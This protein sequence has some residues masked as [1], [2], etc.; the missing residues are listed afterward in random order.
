MSSMTRIKA[1]ALVLALTFVMLA[2]VVQPA[3]ASPT[4]RLDSLKTYI[5]DQYDDVEGGYS[6]RGEKLSRGE[7]TFSV[8]EALN[9]L[10]DLAA[11]PPPIN[12]TMTKEFIT[13]LQW[14]KINEKDDKY[15][16]FS[17]F[18]AGIP[19][20]HASYWTIRAWQVLNQ[21]ND[22][23]G[24]ENVEINETA[25]LV[26]I[27]RTFTDEGGFA[28]KPGKSADL[29]STYEAVYLI[30]YLAK[31]IQEKEDTPYTTTVDKWLNQTAVFDY[32]L[33]CRK[34][35]AFKMTTDAK[36]T[37]VTATAAAILALDVLDR[38]NDLQD[39]QSV[40]D[41]ILDRQVITPIADE[42]VGGF[43]ESY[44]TNDTNLVSTYYALSALDKLGAIDGHVNASIAIEF[45][46]NCQAADGAWALTPGYEDGE[47]TYIGMA[48]MSLK[49]LH[50]DDIRS[51]LLVEDPNNPAP[52]LIDWRLGL[53]ILMLVIAA[54]A[55][56]VGL[57]LD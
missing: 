5:D 18:I 7:A 28:A 13:K 12:L 36:V 26:Y 10:G 29:L 47:T 16:G 56:L 32:I 21:H 22:Y 55:G 50:G 19:S 9:D 34:D 8:L 48:M 52:P 3:S 20:I 25:A 23:I 17:S 31:E 11:R 30:D 45:V 37:G 1:A 39:L 35:D 42:Y 51:L 57:R 27:N 38:L 14:T 2:V 41:W 15:G 40:R 43:T 4:T 44:K 53:V 24:M 6:L 46:I 49:L 33:S 54:I